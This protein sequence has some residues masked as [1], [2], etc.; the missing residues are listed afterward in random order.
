MSALQL[1]GIFGLC[2]LTG[3]F[4]GFSVGVTWMGRR[5]RATLDAQGLYNVLRG[6]R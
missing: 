4:C 2:V 6:S 1:F 3:F 5:V